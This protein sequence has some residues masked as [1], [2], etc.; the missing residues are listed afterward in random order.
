[1]TLA[2]HQPL[3]GLLTMAGQL[4]QQQDNQVYLSHIQIERDPLAV[5]LTDRSQLQLGLEGVALDGEALTGF[6]DTLRLAGLF[7]SVE[8]E[9]RGPPA[10]GTQ[11]TFSIQCAN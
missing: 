10:A 8:L 11:Q 5:E 4:V 2:E 1:L 7:D 6:A 9:R 3:L